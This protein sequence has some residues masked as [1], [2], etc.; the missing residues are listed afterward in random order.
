MI[1]K[2][3]FNS[4]N[5]NNKM[6]F[7]K[8]NKRYDIINDNQIKYDDINQSKKINDNNDFINNINSNNDDN[9]E[10]KKIQ[11]YLKKLRD[12]K[13][14]NIKELKELLDMKY[15]EEKKKNKLP[16]IRSLHM[17]ISQDDLFKKTIDKKI[18][19]FT[20]I[21][22]EIKNSIFRRKKNFIFQK[23]YDLFKKINANHPF[24]AKNNNNIN[25]PS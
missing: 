9:D 2:T 18:E 10:E 7:N 24:R 11:K 20:M 23:D 16:I 4:I 13:P 22:P 5:S 14:K 15:L 12:K 6:N 17:S 19:S 1:P 21:R 25:S 8:E 3:N